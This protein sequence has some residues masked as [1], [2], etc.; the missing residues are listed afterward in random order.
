MTLRIALFL[1]IVL[2]PL[3][4]AALVVNIG[5]DPCTID[6]ETLKK[7]VDRLKKKLISTKRSSTKH[8]AYR[9]NARRKAKGFI[10]VFN[11]SKKN[12]T[13]LAE[14]KAQIDQYIREI[15]IL[16]NPHRKS[17]LDKPEE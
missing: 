15:E 14:R 5:Y 9:R 16:L 2:T 13:C 12:T 17:V 3:S 6:D 4:V 1:V 7:D 11:K 8:S 10:D